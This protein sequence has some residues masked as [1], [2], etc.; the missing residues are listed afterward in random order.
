MNKY[1]YNSKN[2]ETEKLSITLTVGSMDKLIYLML[3]DLNNIIQV[4]ITNKDFDIEFFQYVFYKYNELVIGLNRN[5]QE[6]FTFY[7]DGDYLNKYLVPFVNRSIDLVEGYNVGGY[8][9]LILE[10]RYK[11]LKKASL[12]TL[13]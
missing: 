12:N 6:C 8:K 13:K 1:I 7:V 4:E 5:T 3:Q 10:L 2:N 11:I 9:N